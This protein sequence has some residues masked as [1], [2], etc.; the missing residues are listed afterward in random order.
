MSKKP[1][2]KIVISLGDL[3]SAPPPPPPAPP[4]AVPPA[5]PGAGGAGSVFSVGNILL[6]VAVVATFAG[7]VGAAVL[8]HRAELAYADEMAAAEEPRMGGVVGSASVCLV[9]DASGSMSGAPMQEAKEAAKDFLA[10]MRP[11][12]EI[13]IIEFDSNVSVALG[14][15]LV[16]D[17][18]SEAKRAIDS[19][20]AGGM[21]ALWDAGIEAV[22]LL[23]QADSEFS[24]LVI[25][26]TD[27]MDNRSSNT[28]EALISRAQNAN[29]VIHTVALGVRVDTDTLNRVAEATRGTYSQ[30]TDARQLR[31]IYQSLGRGLR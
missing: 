4:G 16:G 25:L 14:R 9:I 20:R 17:D 22:D 31:G 11:T 29:T 12:D 23:S 19:I 1:G 27:G 28:P 13:S 8:T 3:E 10:E 30:A 7:L 21:T 15:R 26:L 24:R 2:A 5:S 18:L 6:V